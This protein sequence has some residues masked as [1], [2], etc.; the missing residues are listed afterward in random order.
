MGSNKTAIQFLK[1][2][3]KQNEP[4]VG[5]SIFWNYE[6][7]I[8]ELIS[9]GY[10]IRQ[11]HQY[12]KEYRELRV[13]EKTLYDFI[14]RNRNKFFSDEQQ[15]KSQTTTA[16]AVPSK[17]ITENT[18]PSSTINEPTSKD[19]GEYLSCFRESNRDQEDKLLRS[20]FLKVMKVITK[21]L[22]K[23]FSAIKSELSNYE[24]VGYFK[25]SLKQIKKEDD[26]ISPAMYLHL[27]GDHYLGEP[28]PEPIPTKR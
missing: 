21:D 27:V 8:K 9:D 10:T 24:L 20:E 1:E 26:L 12:L 6:H 23:D 3:K 5:K 18:V 16:A 28:L 19:Y 15:Q 14:R 17:Q 4:K 11:I 2:F 25:Y 7:E 13:S 22:K